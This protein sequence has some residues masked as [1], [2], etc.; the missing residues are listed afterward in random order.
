MD[1]ICPRIDR[2]ISCYTCGAQSLPPFQL[3]EASHV[4]CPPCSKHMARCA[5]GGRFARGPHL[6]LDWMVSALKFKCKYR[7][8]IATGGGGGG[9]GSGDDA[10]PLNR[11]YA[12]HELREH[13]RH[14]CTRNAFPCPWNDCDHVARIETAADHYEEAH[15]PFQALIPTDVDRWHD[16]QFII[17]PSTRADFVKKIFNGYF[18]FTM[19]YPTSPYR[20]KHPHLKPQITMRNLNPADQLQYTHDWEWD[21]FRKVIIV[22][23]TIRELY[24]NC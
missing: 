21:M 8:G 2:L 24:D 13:Y 14:E 3:C 5:C 6:L 11:W 22:T 23:V 7:A 12:V 18:M 15:G 1:F 10:C 4:N 19:K 9:G 20:R 16:V 17:P